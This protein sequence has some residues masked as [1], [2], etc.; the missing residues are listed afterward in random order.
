M[1][2][3]IASLAAT[4]A[5]TATAATAAIANVE[6]GSGGGGGRGRTTLL[7]RARVHL[8]RSRGVQAQLHKVRV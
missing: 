3:T 2:Y 4:A 5:T 8:E 7:H 6:R 1:D